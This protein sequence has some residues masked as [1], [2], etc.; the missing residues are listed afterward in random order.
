MTKEELLSF[1]Q[2]SET[3]FRWDGDCLNAWIFANDLSDFYA[4]AESCFDD[5]GVEATITSGGYVCIDLVPLCG[6]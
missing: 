6:H 1:I 4:M 3:D 5:G 2:E